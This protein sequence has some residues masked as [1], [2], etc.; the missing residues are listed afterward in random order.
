MKSSIQT[1]RLVLLRAWITLIV[2]MDT[3]CKKEEPQPY[4]EWKKTF[5]PRLENNNRRDTVFDDENIT[6]S[7]DTTPS[8]RYIWSW[9]DGSKIDTTQT[10]YAIH[11]FKRIGMNIV[12]LRVERGN[13]YGEKTDSI[14][15]KHRVIPLCEF[16]IDSD[17]SLYVQNTS[18]FVANIN[19]GN[20]Q[21]DCS[22]DYQWDFGD[23]SMGTGYHTTHSYNN[24][25]SFLVKVRITRCGGN[26]I[27]VQKRVVVVGSTVT[28]AYK[29]VCSFN[30]GGNV[31]Q[32]TI[33]VQ[34]LPHSPIK[35]EGRILRRSGIN[36]RY[37]GTYNCNPGGCE[38]YILDVFNNLDSIQYKVTR[39]LVEDYTCSGRK[40]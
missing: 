22:F 13:T 33:S 1:T 20:C 24:T 7:T 14:W 9:G 31:F 38:T 30:Q 35:V 29:C 2:L 21:T 37:I 32:D 12:K 4:P 36:N 16:R 6:F 19:T 11:Q 15:V 18:H 23:G 34:N 8:D 5:T 25:G 26:D 3:A 10:I 27:T 28:D 17:D 39:S 40:L